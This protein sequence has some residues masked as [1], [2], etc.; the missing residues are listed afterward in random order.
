M[1]QPHIQLAMEKREM[2]DS[3]RATSH[4]VFPIDVFVLVLYWFVLLLILVFFMFGVIGS[5]FYD[6]AN[7]CLLVRTLNVLVSLVF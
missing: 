5:S 4:S 7:E 1:A 6:V 2:R 3:T